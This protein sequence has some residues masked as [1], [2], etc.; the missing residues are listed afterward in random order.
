MLYCHCNRSA[1]L[2]SKPD[3]IKKLIKKVA[4]QPV[5]AYIKSLNQKILSCYKEEEKKKK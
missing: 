5:I 1:F 3:H 2:S 4:T